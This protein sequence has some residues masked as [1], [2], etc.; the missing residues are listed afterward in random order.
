MIITVFGETHSGIH[1]GLLF[2]N[3][4]TSLLLFVLIRR[5]I[6][7]LAGVAASASFAL[8]SVNPTVQGVFANAEHFVILFVCGGLCVLYSA[9]ASRRNA[10]YFAA[11]ALFGAAILVKQHGVAFSV[12]A[13]AIQFFDGIEERRL[14]SRQFRIESAMLV[15]GLLA[16]Y[17]AVCGFFAAAGSF[18]PFWFWTFQYAAD[19]SSFTSSAEALTYLKR[20]SSQIFSSNPLLWILAGVGV[21]S[22]A[23]NREARRLAAF[24]FALVTCSFIAIT[25]GF[26]FR[27]HY[28]VL[29]LPAS[30][31]CISIAVIALNGFVVERLNLRSSDR[32]GYLILC[33]LTAMSLIQNSEFFFEMTPRQATIS[34]YGSNP[35]DESVE[36]GSYLGAHTQPDE[37]IAVIG[38]EPQIL[39]YAQR[40]SATGFIYTYSLMEEQP[41]AARM[42]QQMIEEIESTKPAYLVWV[43]PRSIRSSWLMNEKSQVEVLNWAVEYK[44][45]HYERVG[46]V[47]LFSDRS[48]FR[49]DRSSIGDPRS[50]N[51]IEILK[52]KD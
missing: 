1:T 10:R 23:W 43:D 47:E 44:S 25:P 16:P 6:N 39:F 51:W 34:L 48:L 35:F 17:A 28:Y 37:R 12:A 15:S 4:G 9:I 38:S 7:P 30:A 42:Q 36:I 8:L 26:V 45:N 49:W 32:P 29:L 20:G 52:R 31:V 27:L 46:M 21:T 24:I 3:T 18:E 22:P 2:V 5:L 50:A 40:R 13:I 11:G 14:G 19:Y 33:A 41:H